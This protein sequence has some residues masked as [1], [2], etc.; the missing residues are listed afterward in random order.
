MSIALKKIAKSSRKI[1]VMLQAKGINFGMTQLIYDNLVIYA[2]NNRLEYKNLLA[3]GDFC[4]EGRSNY[5]KTM[6]IVTVGNGTDIKS[7]H[8]PEKWLP[9]EVTSAISPEITLSEISASQKRKVYR[10][11][12]VKEFKPARIVTVT[13]KVLTKK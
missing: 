11:P 9:E 1:N 13:S 4:F 2:R 7:S 5:Y 10:G 6:I 8:V 3:M 12:G